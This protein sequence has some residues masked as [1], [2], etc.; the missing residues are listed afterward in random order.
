M[1][2][3][4]GIDIFPGLC[5]LPCIAWVDVCYCCFFKAVNRQQRI[6]MFWLH[7]ADIVAKREVG[8]EARYRLS[9]HLAQAWLAHSHRFDNIMLSVLMEFCT[10]SCTLGGFWLWKIWQN[11]LMCQLFLYNLISFAFPYLYL[12]WG[13]KFVIQNRI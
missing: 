12:L 6:T 8:K 11:G 3:P 10:S 4:E 1:E 5:V 7:Q 9:S 13:P 2:L